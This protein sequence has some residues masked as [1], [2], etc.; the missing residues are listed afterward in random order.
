V[1]DLPKLLKD[2][3]KRLDDLQKDPKVMTDPFESIY[4]IVYQLTMR[5]VGCDDIAEDPV[6]LAKTLKY[7]ESIDGSA[8][9]M[10]VMYPWLPSPAVVKRTYAASQLY[11]TVNK[12]VENRKKTGIKGD[13]PL[14]YLIDQGDSMYRIIEFIIGALFAGL[15]NSGINAAWVLT[16]LAND[17]HW[18]SE[19]RKEVEAVAAKYTTN[20]DAPLVDQLND[21]PFQAWESEFPLIDLCLKDSIRLQALGT[22]FRKNISNKSIP[23][24]TGDEVI[25]PGAIVVY[26]LGDVHLNPEIY[27]NPKQWDPS[28]YFPEKAEDK[29]RPMGYLGW[30]VGR[31]PCRKFSS[32][33]VIKFLLTMLCSGNESK[34]SYPKH[35]FVIADKIYSSQN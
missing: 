1:T 4:G 20:K 22:A 10:A 5:M 2:T 21:I 18:R 9:P 34:N 30:G 3:R 26:H 14:Q 24:G 6:L 35:L 32:P 31:H 11:I 16:Y 25:D 28:R 17:S 15:L 8:T 27:P 12:I 33:L 29:K 7:Y 13:D 19:V 23:T